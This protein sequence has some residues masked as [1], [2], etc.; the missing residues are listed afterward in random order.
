M[1]MIVALDVHY[2]HD[3]SGR[4]A[5]VGF[6]DWES[7]EPACEKYLEITGAAPYKPGSFYERELPGLL[8]IIDKLEESPDI[9]IVDGYAWLGEGRPGLGAHL[10]EALGHRVPVVGVAKSRFK[11]ASAA[12]IH[13]GSSWRPLYVTSAGMAVEEAAVA[14][15][16][17]YG[18]HYLPEMLRRVD[19]LARTRGM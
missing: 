18:S 3:D 10:W 8:E 11:G 14:V 13:H 4:V 9:I 7:R 1:E 15:E 2:W 5:A 16:S 19:R 12:E 6:D 17:M